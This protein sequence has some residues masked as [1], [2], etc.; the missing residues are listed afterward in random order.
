MG[1]V[2]RLEQGVVHL[3]EDLAGS[4]RIERVHVVG[5]ALARKGAP[6]LRPSRPDLALRIVDSLGQARGREQ[7]LRADV[8]LCGTVSK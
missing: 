1:A 3:I 6:N 8:L 2:A 7:C 5:D 4:D